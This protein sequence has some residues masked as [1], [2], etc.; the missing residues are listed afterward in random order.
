[1][2]ID[3]FHHIFTSVLYS[4]IPVYFIGMPWLYI[5][6]DANTVC[7]TWAYKKRVTLNALLMRFVL[8]KYH[9]NGTFGGKIIVYSLFISSTLFSCAGAYR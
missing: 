5:N 9:M 6:G 7:N 1:M 3:N 8:A 4:A 2:L